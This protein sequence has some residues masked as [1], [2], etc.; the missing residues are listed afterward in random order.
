[1]AVV[2]VFAAAD[3]GNQQQVGGGLLGDANRFG[4]DPRIAHGVGSGGVFFGGDAE[5]NHA[6]EAQLCH[7]ANFLGQQVGRKLIV[8]GHG[9]DLLPEVFTRPDE[10]RQDQ[11]GR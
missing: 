9:R 11:V 5:E 4:N 3:V 1:M 2:G 8:A 10:Q 7:L 6:A